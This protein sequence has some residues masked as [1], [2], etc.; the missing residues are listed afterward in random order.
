MRLY[1]KRRAAFQRV[2]SEYGPGLYRTAYRLTGCQSEADDLFQELLLKLFRQMPHWLAISHPRPWFMRVLYNLHIDRC[3]KDSRTP[4]M[5]ESSRHPDSDRIDCEPSPER[6]PADALVCHQR[7][8]RIRA[9]LAVLSPE[10][11][12]LVV[13]YFMEGYKLKELSSLLDLPLGSVKS[14]LH[15]AKERLKSKLD[16]E[17][18]ADNLR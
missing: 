16:M 3:R 9:A 6:G 5:A 8:Q 10:Q 17:P 14:R 18:F 11:R 15:R 13:L 7:Q 12:A 4:G 1:G 2:I